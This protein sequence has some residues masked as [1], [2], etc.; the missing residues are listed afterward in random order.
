[1]IK[2]KGHFYLVVLTE[3]NIN[4]P[5]K[6]KKLLYIYDDLKKSLVERFYFDENIDPKDKNLDVI[7]KNMIFIE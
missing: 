7:I 6:G 5:V 1:M 2:A 4:S 3:Q